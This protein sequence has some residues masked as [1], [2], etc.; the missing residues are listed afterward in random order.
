MAKWSSVW[1]WWQRLVA[2]FPVMN[3][4]FFFYFTRV[5]WCV[6][7]KY[8]LQIPK[9]IYIRAKSTLSVAPQCLQPRLDFWRLEAA[10]PSRDHWGEPGLASSLAFTSESLG[11]WKLEHL[12]RS[13]GGDQPGDVLRILGRP[14]C[15]IS[16]PLY[17]TTTLSK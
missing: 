13:G 9:S 2:R 11:L 6:L 1:L 15:R 8:T 14:T 12:T 3:V 7:S 16:A 17:T 4:Y 5:W 10:W